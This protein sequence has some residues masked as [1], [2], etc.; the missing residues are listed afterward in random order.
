MT[1]PALIIEK[2]LNLP[3]YGIYDHAFSDADCTLTLWVRQCWPHPSYTCGGCGVQRKRIISS[4]ERKVRDLNWGGWKIHLVVEMHRIRCPRCGPR[5][6]AIPFLDGKHPFTRRFMLAVAADCDEMPAN[7]AAVRWGLSSRTACRIDKTVLRRWNKTRKRPALRHMGVDELWWRHGE[8]I[9]VVSNLDSSEP[10][11]A[12]VSRKKETLD[13]FFK[14]LTVRQRRKIRAACVDMWEPFRLS[15]REHA[16]QAA[17][18]YDK[19]HVIGHVNKAVDETRRQEFFR[20]GG[21]RRELLRGKRW[22]MLT[23]WRNLKARGRGELNQV[24]ALNR[25]LFKAYYL[26]EEI[27]RLWD[28]TYEGAARTFLNQWLRKLRW[29]RLPAFKKVARLLLRHLDGILAYCRHKVPLGMVE[30][31]NGNL[32]VLISRGRGYRDLEYLLLKAQRNSVLRKH[33][34]SLKKAA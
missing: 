34:R 29:Q 30:A 27:V 4:R 10:I 22:L 5:V 25:R 19:F 24:F 18:V 28:Y 13:A 21:W 14:T 26:R 3:G 1:A 6:E 12:G 23:R 8:F 9:T 11:W 31:I 17:I 32:R 7:R 33:T 20:R 2:I 15:I 16:P